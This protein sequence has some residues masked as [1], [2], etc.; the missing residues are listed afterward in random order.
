MLKGV[1]F[2]ISYPE[3]CEGELGGAEGA[4]GFSDSDKSSNSRATMCCG[5]E[6][7]ALE[8]VA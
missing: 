5:C 6:K 1:K 7:T 2:E 8:S 4:A 3:V